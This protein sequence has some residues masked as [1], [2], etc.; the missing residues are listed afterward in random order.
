MALCSAIRFRHAECKTLNVAAE[1][2]WGSASLEVKPVFWLKPRHA[3]RVKEA[4]R[5]RYGSAN[6]RR[7][8]VKDGAAFRQ[9]VN[10]GLGPL[11]LKHGQRRV[12][13]SDKS[14][15][16]AVRAAPA[17]YRCIHALRLTARSATSGEPAQ[18][19]C[20]P[21]PSVNWLGAFV[22]I[23]VPPP[24]GMEHAGR[25]PTD[26]GNLRNEPW[27]WQQVSAPTL[28]LW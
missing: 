10:G 7:I 17:G 15:V 6:T 5:R 11:L 1:S 9:V 23:S 2:W 3:L 4:E 20:A 16:E 18:Q 22:A 26:R 13:Y 19:C 8:S 14:S 27:P 21:Q 12:H 25:N 28:T 24:R